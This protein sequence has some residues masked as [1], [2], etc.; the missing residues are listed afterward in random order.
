MKITWKPPSAHEPRSKLPDSAFAFPAERKEPLTNAAHVRSAIGRFGS[1][2][3]VSDEERA[4]A[5]TNIQAAAKYYGVAV[6]SLCTIG[7]LG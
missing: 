1:V 3:G 7:P 6:H 4:Q 5:V 2:T